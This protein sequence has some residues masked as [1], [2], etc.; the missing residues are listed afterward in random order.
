MRRVTSTVWFGLGC[1]F[2]GSLVGT[3]FLVAALLDFPLLDHFEWE[4]RAALLGGLAALPL[5]G[6]LALT[7]SSR[8]S[9]LA[10]VRDFLNGTA[11]MVFGG[12]TTWHFGAISLLA[13]V[14]EELL[15]RGALQSGLE[16]PLGVPG[17]LLAASVLFGLCHWINH[18]YAFVA[19]AVGLYLG[20]LFLVTDNLLAPIVCHA[21]YD[22]GALV[23]LFR[24]RLEE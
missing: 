11:R 6:M 7:M 4:P 23:W 18:T 15:F 14:G 13:G 21:V 3:A 1:L 16:S 5:F 24:L 17:A 9:W 10:P 2:E 19:M 12:W 8:A 22:F 20:G